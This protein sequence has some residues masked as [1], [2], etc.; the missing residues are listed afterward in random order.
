[1]NTWPDFD[2]SVRPLL[3]RASKANL[4]D[5]FVPDE[6]CQRPRVQQEFPMR[7]LELSGAAPLVQALH[8]AMEIGRRAPL[9]KVFVS[10]FE[11]G[12]IERRS[13]FGVVELGYRIWRRLPTVV[14][15]GVDPFV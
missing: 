7:T 3:G 8:H 10:R 12:L 14:T 1:L 15:R 2:V 13:S 9:G 11:F 5:G 6:F 4:I